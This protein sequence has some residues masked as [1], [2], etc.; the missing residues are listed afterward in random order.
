MNEQWSPDGAA[1]KIFGDYSP[2][3]V[4]VLKEV[5]EHFGSTEVTF[6]AIHR[7]RKAGMLPRFG[8]SEAWPFSM[9]DIELAEENVE[10]GER[11]WRWGTLYPSAHEYVRG[12]YRA[13]G[14]YGVFAGGTRVK[15]P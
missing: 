7:L 11:Y 9:R 8:A 12:Y 5:V 6:H 15:L 10:R 1:V 2:H 14:L 4:I 13:E 3:P